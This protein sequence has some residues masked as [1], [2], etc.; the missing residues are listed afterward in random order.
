MA[1]KK[2]NYEQLGKTLIAVAESG[3]ISSARFYKY[4]FLKGFIAGIGGVV[5]ATVGIALL[6]FVLSLFDQ[7][8]L[9]GDLTEVIRR[10]LEQNN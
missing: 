1:G 7:I 5:G 2:P 10:T 4:S 3:Y 8:P 9:L 6:L